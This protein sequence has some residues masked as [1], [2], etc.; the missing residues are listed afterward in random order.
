MARKSLIEELPEIVK[1]GRREYEKIMQRLQ[2]DN[3]MTLQTNEYVLPSKDVS[4]LFQGKIRQCCPPDSAEATCEADNWFNRLIYGDNIFVMQAL[5]N[6]DAKTGLPSMRGAIDLI[7]IDPPFDSKADYRTK[8]TLPNGDIEAKPAVIDQFAYS[9]TWK[10]GTV[11]YLEMLY[12]RLMLMRDLLSDN[13]SIYVHIDQSIGHYVKIL[14]DDVF[15]KSNFLSEIIWYRYNKIPDKTK[16]LWFKMH[17]TIYMYAKNKGNTI[18][19]PLTTKTGEMITR[20]AMKKIN[21]KIV[22][23][24]DWVTY[25][26]EILETRSVLTN[27][28]DINIGSSGEKCNYGTQ[29]PE[30]LLELLLKASTTEN[31]IVADFFGGSGTTAAVAEK[32]GRRWIT[33]DIGKPSTMIMRKRM[34]DNDA[35]PFLYHAIGDYQREAFM[36]SHDTSLKRVSDLARVVMN[37][38]GAKP[39]IGDDV[40]ANYGQMGRTLV[41][42]DSPNKVTSAATIN[43]AIKARESFM[44]GWNKVIVLGWNFSFDIAQKIQDMDKSQLEVLVIPPDLLDLLKKKDYRDLVESGRVRFSSLQYLTIK[45]P[46]VA[47]S[48]TEPGKEDLTI[49]LDNY[50]LLSPDVLPLDDKNKE[51]I[52]NV[53]ANNPLDLIEYWSIDP[54]YDGTTFRSVWQDYRENTAN[55]GDGLRVV[56]SAKITVEPVKNRKICVKAVDVF[57]FESQCVVEVK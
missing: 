6:G 54:D 45:K 49:E 26:K 28:P 35:K 52:Q 32:L 16:K 7:Y 2:S 8:I 29:K 11:S 18:F 53:I 39:F 25:E 23:T 44:G 47:Q 4:G 22:N 38:Y 37:L 15:G 27:I 56:R 21:G 19:N 55:D 43:N 36:A 40:P 31:S 33:S 42:V 9:D 13:G 41:I 24:D 30:K 17:D 5:L 12:P 10:N 14:L 3:K 48:T 20:K 50:V 51:A 34:I 46:V 1:R 57:G